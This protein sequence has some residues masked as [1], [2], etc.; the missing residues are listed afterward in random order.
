MHGSHLPTPGEALESAGEMV[1]AL[2]QIFVAVEATGGKDA[3]TLGELVAAGALGPEAAAAF[4][5]AIAAAPEVA[6]VTVSAYVGACT[7]CMI[8]GSGAVDALIDALSSADV[9]PRVKAALQDQG[10]A[11]A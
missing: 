5:A 6:A 1:E 8:A 2:H 3:I 11:V 10:V 9:D 4:S 7:G